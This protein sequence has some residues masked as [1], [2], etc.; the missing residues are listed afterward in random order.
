MKRYSVLLA[1]I[2]AIS[3]IASAQTSKRNAAKVNLDSGDLAKAKELIDIAIENDK[4]KEDA[5]TWL[6]YGMIYS[7]IG[8]ST[9]ENIKS[10]AP[11]GLEKALEAYQKVTG[12]DEKNTLYLDLS[13]NVMQLANTFYSNGIANFEGQ[14]FDK[15]IDCFNRAGM[16][17]AIIDVVDTMTVYATALSASNGGIDD[18][19]KE[20]YTKL[21]VMGYNNPAIY[22]E[23]AT[24][25]K[26]EENFEKAEEILSQG[27]AKYPENNGILIAEINILLGQ[28]R[29]DEVIS[30]LK[31]SIELEPEN[32]S[33]Y[34][35][36]GDSYKEIK[37]NE[38]A[39]KYYQ[40]ALEIDPDYFLA[41][42]NLGVVYYQRAFDLNMEANDLPFDQTEKYDKIML[43]AN[44]YFLKGL[45]YFER[46]HSIDAEDNDV[47]KALRQI[48]TSTRQM[49][50]L[51]EL[52]NL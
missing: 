46:A 40:E 32:A 14:V 11:D 15:A 12:Y 21:I 2:F 20:T 44:E 8:A 41:L 49:D 48:Y 3:M 33:L 30:K 43:E 39:I 24:V 34:L 16:S 26:K 42:Y 35:A 1:F 28:G 31:K 6:Y 29:F 23:L 9:D 47:I 51:K 17:N 5:K 25:Y 37:N 18:V 36:L 38:E 10:L 45:P 52:N 4:T 7:K 22:S 19:A 27:R 13:T 50:K